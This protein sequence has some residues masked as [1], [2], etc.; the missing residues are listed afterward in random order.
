[1]GVAL[2]AEHC[3]GTTTNATII[4]YKLLYRYGIVSVTII[5]S[6]VLLSAT[7]HGTRI[8]IKSARESKLL[9]NPSCSWRTARSTFK[10]SADPDLIPCSGLS[11]PQELERYR[12]NYAYIYTPHTR[13]RRYTCC[14]AANHCYNTS[15]SECNCRATGIVH[16]RT[17][18]RLRCCEEQRTSSSTNNNSLVSQKEIVF[19]RGAWQRVPLDRQ[20]Q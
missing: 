11:T 6:A 1:M 9:V 2:K 4:S 15:S 17:G 10:P 8:V 5:R 19:D 12:S 14:C 16:T 18:T 20:H 3:G 7:V 13:V